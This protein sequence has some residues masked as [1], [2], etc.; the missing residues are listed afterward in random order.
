MEEK[1]IREK[2]LLNRYRN[3]LCSVEEQLLVDNWFN[4]EARAAKENNDPV[5]VDIRHEIWNKLPV[6]SKA[7][8]IKLWPRIAAV[9]SIVLVL[10]G[11]ALFY[12]NLHYSVRYGYKNDVA[13]GKIG[14][15]L[16]LANGRK[17]SL[18]NVS[19]GQIAKE[20][21]VSISKSA[22]GQLLYQIAVSPS[23]PGRGDT[24]LNTVSTARGQ[25]Y[26]V[27]L[28]DGSKVWLNAASSLTF[29]A[30]LN[31]KGKRKVKLEGEGY[32]EVAKDKAH[33]FVVES[34]GQEVEVLGTHFNI[35]AYKGEASIKTTLIE[36]SVKVSDYMQQKILVPGTESVKTA[37][38][39]EIQNVDAALAVAWKNDKLVFENEKIG[40]V[41]KMV[42]RWYDVQVIYEGEKPE[43]VFGGSVSRFDN[44]SK[45]LNILESTGRVHFEVK[46][47]KIYVSK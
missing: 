41:M 40:P 45:V 22:K 2:E 47:K 37:K 38:G 27:Y 17:I 13:P 29:S 26:Q 30:N 9:A 44:V 16:T 23:V 28:S 42:E 21:G 20:A 31:E 19:S 24:Q 8:T 34:E 11:V 12:N 33:P 25:T 5:D 32:F 6:A 10:I 18:N 39:I 46:G 15:T 3:G 14:A 35:N 43:D 36:G 4:L 1:Y 7:A